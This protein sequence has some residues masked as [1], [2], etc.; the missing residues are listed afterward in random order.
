MDYFRPRKTMITGYDDIG[1]YEHRIT[2]LRHLSSALTTSVK[3]DARFGASK[4]S[5]PE[6]LGWTGEFG[7]DADCR[8]GPTVPNRP[9]EGSKGAFF[10]CTLAPHRQWRITRQQTPPDPDRS[11]PIPA[12]L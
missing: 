12:E 10:C 1:W 4:R 3:A 7:R 5:G 9:V 6:R 2:Q 8:Y 11:S